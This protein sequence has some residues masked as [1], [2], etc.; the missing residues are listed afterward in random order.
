MSNLPDILP[1]NKIKL[2]PQNHAN[3]FA[4]YF[5]NKVNLI[6][7]QTHID[8]GVYNGTSRLNM[9]NSHFMTVNDTLK[10]LKTIKNKNCDGFYR[11]PQRI[12]VVGSEILA[13]PLGGLFERIYNQKN[14]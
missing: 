1:E 8:P 12:L 9:K 13:A 3:A 7:N 10:C 6:V 5:H 2:S 11:I 14:S 4:Q